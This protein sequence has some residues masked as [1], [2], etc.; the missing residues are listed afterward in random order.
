MDNE[1]TSTT[2]EPDLP[3][4]PKASPPPPDIP[5]P[6]AKKEPP[7]S[8]LDRGSD[9]PPPATTETDE[10]PEVSTGPAD[11]TIVTDRK[12]RFIGLAIDVVIGVGIMVVLNFFSNILGFLGYSAYLLLR[13]ALPFLDGQSVGKGVMNLRAVDSEGNHLTG[14][15]LAS[16][17]RNIL[18]GLPFV[19]A[20]ADGIVFYVR[21][22]DPREGL[23]LGD[24]WA[25]TKTVSVV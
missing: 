12:R 20:L 22:G 4:P 24:D 3:T 18:I 2:P 7:L 6:S 19:G 11:P 14:N 5:A 21:E 15:Y 9:T 1:P 16:I 8:K 23:R 17:K 25:G 13:D 10:D